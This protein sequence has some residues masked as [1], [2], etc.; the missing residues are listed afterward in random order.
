MTSRSCLVLSA[1]T[2]LIAGCDSGPK[3]VSVSGRVTLDSKPLPNAT[4]QFL[5]EPGSDDK[6][7]RTSAIGTTDEDGRYSLVL[8]TSGNTKG[9]QVGKY[10]VMITLGM[11]SEAETKRTY[12]KQLPERYN[13]RTTLE[14]EVPAAGREDANFSLTSRP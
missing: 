6:T 10:K 13:R 14:C 7:P 9:A 12:H 3:V 11:R 5:P 8:N 2:L 1:L 4:L